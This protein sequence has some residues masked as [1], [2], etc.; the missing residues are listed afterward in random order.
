M[1]HYREQFVKDRGIRLFKNKCSILLASTSLGQLLDD[2]QKS[3]YCLNTLKYLQGIA[4]QPQ[5]EYVGPQPL[6]LADFP[7]LA[8]PSFCKFV[9]NEIANH[10]RCGRLRL[11]TPQ[12]YRD[13]E[14]I[15]RA[16][17]M[18]GFAFLFAEGAK[19]S[20]NLAG[21]GA[22]NTVMLC[23]VAEQPSDENELR[24]MRERFGSVLINIKDIKVFCRIV[25]NKIRAIRYRIRDIKYIDG[26]FMSIKMANIDK[27]YMKFSKELSPPRRDLNDKALREL[28]RAYWKH[29]YEHL[30]MPAAFSKPTRYAPER[31]RRLL[32]EL[33]FDV[34]EPYIDIEIPEIAKFFRFA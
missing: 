24:A 10:L 29:F 8:E 2:K 32:F 28:N 23:G 13:M 6:S 30:L 16:D 9:S 19:Y 33:P 27:F 21:T 4:D 34:N 7:V 14:D 12:Y 3:A 5:T 1:V 31:E 25:C 22:F 15:N 11:G 18:E 26:K 17:V 20:V